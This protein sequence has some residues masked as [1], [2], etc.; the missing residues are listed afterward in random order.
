MCTEHYTACTYVCE[1]YARVSK[2]VF[3]SDCAEVTVRLIDTQNPPSWLAIPLN[4]VKI[5]DPDVS[6]QTRFDLYY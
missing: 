6:L 3:P 1:D 4:V 2:S 5:V